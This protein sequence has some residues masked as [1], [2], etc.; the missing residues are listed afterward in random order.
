M[1]EPQTVGEAYASIR[2]DQPNVQ[3]QRTFL[4][5]LLGL[6]PLP[7][8]QRAFPEQTILKP[9]GD[10]NDF[11]RAFFRPAEKRKPIPV[12][13]D[14]TTIRLDTARLLVTDLNKSGQGE[15]AGIIQNYVKREAERVAI[16][17]FRGNSYERSST[18]DHATDSRD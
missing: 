7:P 18:Q 11:V 2:S 9:V 5:R 14:L 16:G 8:P 15:L 12:V 6:P 13:I 17:T 1:N 10:F 3:Q 4:E